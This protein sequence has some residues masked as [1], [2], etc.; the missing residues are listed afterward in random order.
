[1]RPGRAARASRITSP[2]PT[3]TTSASTSW[4][5][6]SPAAQLTGDSSGDRDL[7]GDEGGRVV[8]H[9]L[10]LEHG[11]HPLGELQSPGDRRRR[12]GIRRRDDGT[13]HGRGGPGQP[14]EMGDDRDDAHGRES[15][16]DREHQNRSGL[17]PELAERGALRGGEE[18]RGQNDREYD[19]GVHGQVGQHRH[20]GQQQPVDQEQDRLRHADDVRDRREHDDADD[21]QGGEGERHGH[22]PTGR[23][24]VRPPR[25]PSRPHQTDP[26]SPRV[27]S[28][29]D[30]DP[31]PPLTTPTGTFAPTSRPARTPASACWVGVG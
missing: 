16:P 22:S 10:A 26:R 8:E 6:A 24:P 27:T 21:D 11:D 13:Q 9:P 25:G 30:G 18:Q 28:T 19:G 7:V 31:E 2:S 4:I 17:V 15:E 5:A 23:W 1:M 14:R 3:P 20:C 12:H 29:V